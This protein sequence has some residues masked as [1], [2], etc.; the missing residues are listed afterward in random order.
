MWIQYSFYLLRHHQYTCQEI[1]K[2]LVSLPG[3]VRSKPYVKDLIE[4]MC[5]NEY[6]S[7]SERSVKIE[8]A[9]TLKSTLAIDTHTTLLAQ[10]ELM[11]KKLYESSLSQ[12]NMSQI[13]ALKYDFCGEGHANGICFLEGSSEEA[14]FANF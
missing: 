6:H 1:I 7:K 12:A 8:S 5:L 14:Q 4:N 9:G 10:I 2:F 3:E 11:N 13:Q